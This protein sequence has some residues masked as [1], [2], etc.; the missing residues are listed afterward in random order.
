MRLR[1]DLILRVRPLKP[2]GGGGQISAAY[3]PRTGG[4]H[5]HAKIPVFLKRKTHFGRKL[6]DRQSAQA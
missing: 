1:R 2:A 6:Q 5:S 3:G 4:P